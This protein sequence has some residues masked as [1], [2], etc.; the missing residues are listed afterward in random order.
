MRESDEE[1]HV[2]WCRVWS[3]CIDSCS[4]NPPIPPW[5]GD[6]EWVLYVWVRKERETSRRRALSPCSSLDS[7]RIPPERMRE[8]SWRCTGSRNRIEEDSEEWST[9]SLVIT[10]LDQTHWQATCPYQTPQSDSSRCSRWRC[11]SIGSEGTR[12]EEY[13]SFGPPLSDTHNRDCCSLQSCTEPVAI[14]LGSDSGE[15]ISPPLLIRSCEPW[16]WYWWVY[17]SSSMQNRNPCH[18]F[19]MWLK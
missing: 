5:S 10:S 14:D 4:S 1:V 16:W 15:W 7:E 11:F 17:D 8:W 19:N 6:R 18:L 13:T 3:E 12:F 9:P 2:F